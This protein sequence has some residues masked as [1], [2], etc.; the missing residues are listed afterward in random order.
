[1]HRGQINRPVWLSL[2]NHRQ[3]VQLSLPAQPFLEQEQIESL[4]TI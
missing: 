1:M 2:E 3:I 4:T